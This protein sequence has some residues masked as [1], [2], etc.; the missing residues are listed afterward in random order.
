VSAITISILVQ[1]SH[2]FHSSHQ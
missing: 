2:F 1:F